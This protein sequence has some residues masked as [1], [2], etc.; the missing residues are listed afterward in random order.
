LTE[1][2]LGVLLKERTLKMGKY[3]ILATLTALLLWFVLDSCYQSD[4]LG[5]S[6]GT[7]LEKLP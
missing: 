2:H 5:I 6:S 1:K 4:F 3:L 7:Y